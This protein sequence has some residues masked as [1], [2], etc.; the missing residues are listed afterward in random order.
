M[1]FTQQLEQ[2]QELCLQGWLTPAYFSTLQ[3]AEQ[4]RWVVA[5][6]A[7]PGHGP[8]PADGSTAS[9][10]AQQPC[11]AHQAH[12]STAGAAEEELAGHCAQPYSWT[13]RCP[14]V[15][16]KLTSQTLSKLTS[17]L[18][19]STPSRSCAQPEWIEL[20][21]PAY[22]CVCVCVCVCLNVCLSVCICADVCVWC[23]C[24][25]F[26]HDTVML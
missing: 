10:G 24:T 1:L 6:S 13:V 14:L 7:R 18:T 20:S 22:A 21:C 3:S 4:I 8:H 23:G 2:G 12:H 15:S 26:I 9:T 11:G 25:F 17:N 16:V 19:F 5:Q